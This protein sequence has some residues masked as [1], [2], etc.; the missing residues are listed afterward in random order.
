MKPKSTQ[1]ILD[2]DDSPISK[3]VNYFIKE[4]TKKR[5]GSITLPQ[6]INFIEQSPVGRLDYMTNPKN[7]NYSKFLSTLSLGLEIH[8]SQQAKGKQLPAKPRI[9]Q[10]LD[11]TNLESPRS[12]TLLNL[13]ADQYT[14]GILYQFLIKK[15]TEIISLIENEAKKTDSVFNLL[16]DTPLKMWFNRGGGWNHP[17]FRTLL[18]DISTLKQ[19]LRKNKRFK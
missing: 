11:D 16:P 13:M 19:A 10:I 7:S 6:I 8:N 5:K 3:A 18:S 4:Y 1:S 9:Q 12:R 15:N 14:S 17:F 2:F